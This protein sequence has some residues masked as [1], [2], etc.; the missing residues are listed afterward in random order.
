LLAERDEFHVVSDLPKDGGP[1]AQVIIADYDKGVSLARQF[2]AGSELSRPRV[3]I[4]SHLD[5]QVQ[6]SMAVASGVW[7]YLLQCCHADD[8][9]AAIRDLSKGMSHM[10][11]AICPYVSGGFIGMPLTRREM[12]VL[13][14]LAEGH[15]NKTISRELGIGVGTV[16]TYLKGIMFKLTAKARTHAVVIASRR[17]LV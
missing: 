7:G 16:K 8:L 1:Q 10:S 4:L 5:K 14:L 9:V 17:G 13:N 12:D 6:V 15:C 11:A 3:L 2:S